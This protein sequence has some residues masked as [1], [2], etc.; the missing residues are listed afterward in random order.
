MKKIR[1]YKNYTLLYDLQ[2]DEGGYILSIEKSGSSGT[3]KSA[4]FVSGPECELKELLCRLWRC[5][6]TPMSLVYILEDEGYL[7][8][9]VEPEETEKKP[10][11]HIARR[12]RKDRIVSTD[13]QFK[14]ESKNLATS[15][16]T[17]GDK[18]I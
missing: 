14:F 17:Q 6:V 3:E 13:S 7:P 11:V 12:T 16:C 2:K 4:Y 5:G 8:K 9:L 18:E 15:G 1:T 10:P